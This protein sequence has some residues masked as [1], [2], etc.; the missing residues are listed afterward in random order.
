MASNPTQMK[1]AG[2]GAGVGVGT[3]N[4]N[5]P[6][7][8]NAKDDIAKEEELEKALKH[9]DLLHVELGAQS[10]R[11]RTTIPRL[12]EGVKNGLP[13]DVVFKTVT[14]SIQTT[15]AEL[16]DFTTLYRGEESRKVLEQ[17][18]KSREANPKG[19]KPW[20]YSD[21]PDWLDGADWLWNNKKP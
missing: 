21:H 14:S 8:A 6:T 12:M 19:I 17:A 13:R 15:Q 1:K 9:L 18:K 7:A 16:K 20:R 10:R 4:G 2:V 3:S 5:I 11:L